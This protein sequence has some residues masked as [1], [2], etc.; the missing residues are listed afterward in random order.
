MDTVPFLWTT[1]LE[2]STVLCA[3][4]LLPLRPPLANFSFLLLSSEGSLRRSD[5]IE[6]YL[7]SSVA[8]GPVPLIRVTLL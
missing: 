8:H 4:R 2:T 7:L 3:W 1:G 6:N 5:C